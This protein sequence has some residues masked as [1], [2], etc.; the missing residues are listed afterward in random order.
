MD[1]INDQTSGLPTLEKKRAGL[2]G[3]CVGTAGSLEK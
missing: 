2:G 3:D 1:G